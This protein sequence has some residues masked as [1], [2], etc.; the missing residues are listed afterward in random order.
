MQKL[1]SH[2]PADTAYLRACEPAVSEVTA[3]PP[4][5]HQSRRAFD[6]PREVRGKD[7]KQPRR[8][9]AS[10]SEVDDRR[11]RLKTTGAWRFGSRHDLE[12]PRV[13]TGQEEEPPP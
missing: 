12:S 4:R 9:R 5:H 10:R 1:S 7:A 13:S 2:V 8:Q 11:R 3:V 6:A